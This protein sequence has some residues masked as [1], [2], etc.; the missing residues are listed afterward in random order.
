M[1]VEV[2]QQVRI[3]I[4]NGYPKADRAELDR[5]GMTSADKL[6]HDV[7]NRRFP[8]LQ[9][10]SLFLADP[11][12]P[13]PA[14]SSLHDFDAFIWTGSKLTI[15][16]D[17]PEVKRQI[18]FSRALFEAGK[19]QCGSCWGVQMAAVAAGGE[20]LK[21]EQGRET[22]IA[23]K[24]TLTPEGR[25]SLL[26][27][28]KPDVFDGFVNHLD[29]VTRIPDSGVLLATGGHCHVQSLEVKHKKGTF[30][31]LQYHPEYNLM[32]MAKLMEARGD[33]LINEGF[34]A[35]WET[36]KDMTGKM[37]RLHNDPS[38][39]SL[40]QE[41]DVGADILDDDLREAEIVNYFKHLVLPNLRR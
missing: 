35:N 1:T 14:G 29:E 8:E 16:H 6:Y 11:D 34:F 28:G 10:E 5:A 3:G 24:H 2:R 30:W 37:T 40:K 4:I 9:L 25:A 31:G 27:E 39:E 17:I 38:N 12:V 41:L 36:L 15:Y 7:L 18:A 26:Y 23:R 22:Y 21:M 32:E 20:V 33:A 19:P 13:V